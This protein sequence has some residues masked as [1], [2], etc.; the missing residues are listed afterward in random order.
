MLNDKYKN[1]AIFG[2]NPY[3]SFTIYHSSFIIAA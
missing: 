3:L 1:A 2:A